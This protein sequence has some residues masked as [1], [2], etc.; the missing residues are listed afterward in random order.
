MVQNV[1]RL[2]T[3]GPSRLR[4]LRSYTKRRKRGA[5]I[6]KPKSN[7]SVVQTTM[8]CF[9][10]DECSCFVLSIAVANGTAKRRPCIRHRAFQGASP[11]FNQDSAIE[12]FSFRVVRNRCHDEFE[13]RVDECSRLAAAA[14]NDSDRAFW[15]G[16]VERWR[17]VESRRPILVPRRQARLRSIALE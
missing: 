6:C 16:L 12:A 7:S 1:E 5:G 17:A 4:F 15:L 3:F 9:V 8:T 10:L 13:R 14:R 2:K 11:M